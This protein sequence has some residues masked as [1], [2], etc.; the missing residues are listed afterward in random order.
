MARTPFLNGATADKSTKQNNY[1]FVYF[2]QKV[3]SS[4]AQNKEEQDKKDR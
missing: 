4:Q 3:K 1:F 2:G